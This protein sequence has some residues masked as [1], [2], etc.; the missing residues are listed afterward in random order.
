MPPQVVTE[1]PERLAGCWKRYRACFWTQTRDQSGCAYH[2]LSGLLRMEANRNF[3]RIGRVTG[4]AGENIQYFMSNSPWSAQVVCRQVR[5]EITA[6]LPLQQGSVLILD[7][8]VDAKA[9]L[10]SAGSA[11]QHNGRLG[12]EDV[13]QV[14]V[15]LALANGHIWTWVDGTLF[16]PELW[17]TSEYAELRPRA[18]IPD[19]WTFKTKV[20][21][22]WEM[23]QRAQQAG[24]PFEWVTDVRPR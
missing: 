11:C 2:Y 22:G 18:G 9:G 15:F 6:T 8:S 3:S 17:F 23:I 20:Q 19:G 12:K 1:L 14:G 7:E 21:L 4:Q 5:A 24:L 16:L 10:H 13:C